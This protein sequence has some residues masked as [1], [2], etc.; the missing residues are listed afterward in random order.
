MPVVDELLA[1]V[2]LPQLDKSAAARARLTALKIYV[3]TRRFLLF[4]P[5][6]AYVRGASSDCPTVTYCTPHSTI[7]SILLH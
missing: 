5:T 3:V 4:I 6:S 1:V 7:H 2:L